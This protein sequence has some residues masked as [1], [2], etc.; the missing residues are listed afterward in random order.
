MGAQP[1]GP[2]AEGDEAMTDRMTPALVAA[3]V[4]R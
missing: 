1:E 3:L 2:R 4:Q